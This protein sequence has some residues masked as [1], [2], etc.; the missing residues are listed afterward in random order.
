MRHLVS[1]RLAV[2]GLALA[3]PTVA[4]SDPPEAV[5]APVRHGLFGRHHRHTCPNCQIKAQMRANGQNGLPDGVIQGPPVAG[6]T[7]PAAPGAPCLACQE[8]AGA[9]VMIMD[10]GEMAGHAVIGGAPSGHAVAGM[11]PPTAEPAPIGVVQAGYRPA[12]MPSPMAAGPASGYP[13]PNQG[14][15]GMLP[16]A[17]TPV[18]PQ[19][20]NRPRILS[21]L[22]GLETGRISRARR[23]RMKSEHASI[24]YD[25]SERAVAE[26]PASMVY[27]PR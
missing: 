14:G 20:A 16:G 4:W 26:L 21:H 24:R 18:R 17:P 2:F 11:T 7:M 19:R 13:A 23:E 22:F 5:Q 9:P 8:S 3:V 15:A 27:G 1:M 12:S 6:M 25:D 10:S